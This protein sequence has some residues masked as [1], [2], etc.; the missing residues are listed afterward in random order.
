MHAILA[1]GSSAA[2]GELNTPGVA[3]EFLRAL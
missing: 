3:G 2:A 1:D